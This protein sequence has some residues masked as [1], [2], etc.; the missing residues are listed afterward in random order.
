MSKIASC[1]GACLRDLLP[2]PLVEG[3]ATNFPLNGLMGHALKAARHQVAV[4]PVTLLVMVFLLMVSHRTVLHLT[5]SHRMDLH[6]VGLGWTALRRLTGDFCRCWDRVGLHLPTYKP[7]AVAH[8][9]PMRLSL[10]W[11]GHG[12]LPHSM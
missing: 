1:P 9:K 12:S 5:V 3:Q 11:M 4:G 2:H 10:S 8:C 6:Q 7:C